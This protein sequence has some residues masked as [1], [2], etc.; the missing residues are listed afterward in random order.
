MWQQWDGF[1]FSG[2]GGIPFLVTS[3]GYG[4]LLNS[5]WASRFAI[6][7]AQPAEC[8]KLAKPEGPWKADQHSGEDHPER[9]AILTEG[10][11]MDLFVIHG[12]DYKSIIKGYSDLTGYAPLLPKWALGW[13]QS[14]NRYKT[15]EQ[16][17]EIGRRTRVQEEGYSL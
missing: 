1:R 16:F 11:D 13:I 4:I 9:F 17:L 10:G 2:N 15:Q 5:S 7:K 14:K 3:Q 6:G 8:S 12:P